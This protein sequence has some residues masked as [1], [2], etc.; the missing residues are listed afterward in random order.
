MPGRIPQNFLDELVARTDI[1]EVIGSRIPLKKAGREYKA[2]CPF[3]GEKTPSFTVSPDKQFYH[4]FGCQA[5]GTALGFLMEHDRLGFIDAV[6]ELASRAGMEIPREAREAADGP[7]RELYDLT[8]AVSQYYRDELKGD[9]RAKEYLLGRGLTG[10][11]CARFGIGYAPDSWNA[12]LRKF[13]SAEAGRHRLVGAGLIIERDGPKRGDD[14][15]YDRFR[16]RIMFPIRDAR[17]RVIGFGGRVLDKGE[18]KYL[19][20]PETSLF[21][22][23]RELYGFYEARQSRADLK[24]LM[25]V[26]GYMDVVR[27]H[28]A[29]IT[30]AVATLGT[31]TTQEHLTR[32][33]RVGNEVVFSFDGDR[34]GRAA[35]WRALEN[36][37]SQAKEGRQ[38]R[39]LFLPEGHDPDTLVGEEG[40]EKFERR[41][42]DALPL[43][44]YLVQH[45]ASQVDLEHVDGRAR[46]AELARPL[47]AKVPPGVYRE[48]LVDRLAETVRMPGPRLAALLKLESI[49]GE[50]AA[51]VDERDEPS[52]GATLSPGRRNL[53]RQAITLTL[54]HP[55]AAAAVA[56]P[57][58]LAD[59]DR[60]GIA[61]LIEL[62]KAAAGAPKSTLAG[63]L[64]R[65]R[66]R[67]EGTHLAKLAISELPE[68]SREQAA[69]ELNQAVNKLLADGS[70]ARRRDA[71]LVKARSGQLTSEEKQELQKLLAARTTPGSP[72]PGGG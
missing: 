34:A 64:E 6:E 36:A 44:E 61:L 31:A 60:P 12:V 59:V 15:H 30:Y 26:E 17:G 56:D 41:L 23:G 67:P 54:H 1:I 5:H 16:D 50:R 65:W 49:P 13:G 43:S 47:I 72:Q 21:H 25:V 45:L 70:P 46:L 4:C 62:L 53:V 24:R 52:R 66:D 7:D 35:A 29:G 14:N 2:C 48:L 27:L 68:L 28:Q 38:I 37:L 55:H 63:L 51:N 3:H 42:A 11:T 20:S 69:I 10:E 40:A 32:L 19:N 57:D 71:L 58:A 22:K 9:A 18:P 33:F 39:F 8:S